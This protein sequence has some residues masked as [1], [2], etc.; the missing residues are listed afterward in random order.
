LP[1]AVAGRRNGERIP[2]GLKR[3]SIR[4]RVKVRVRLRVKV[5]VRARV[6]VRVRARVRRSPPRRSYLLIFCLALPLI[7]LFL[8]YAL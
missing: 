5:R 2:P 7:L 3:P 6:R 1:R 8:Y 4:L